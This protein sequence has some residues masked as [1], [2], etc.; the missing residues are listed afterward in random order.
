MRRGRSSICTSDDRG[1]S[2]KYIRCAP[3]ALLFWVSDFLAR[4]A[5]RLMMMWLGELDIVSQRCL[6]EGAGLGLVSG[7]PD[8]HNVVE[9]DGV[10]VGM[11]DCQSTHHQ[12]HN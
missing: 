3:C 6:V 8:S 9:G 5:S 7:V 1:P 12:I 11:A 2:L 10:G 4:K